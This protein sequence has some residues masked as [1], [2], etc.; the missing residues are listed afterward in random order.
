MVEMLKGIYLLSTDA[1]ELIYGGNECED[2]T[3]LVDIY[4]PPQTKE[5]V[6][7][8]PA[9]LRDADIIFSGW[10]TSRMDADFLNAATRLRAVF[11]AAGSIR[12]VVSEAFWTR[13][14]LITSAYAA[15]AIPVAEYTLS[16]ILF[17]LKL[18]WQHYI[19]VRKKKTWV[20]YKPVFG[21][22]KSTVG[23]ISLGVISRKVI[24]LL[25]PFDLK[26]LVY[27]NHL[28]EE[29]ATELNVEQCS[30]DEIFERADVV[31]LHSPSLEKTRG[32]I[33]GKH[34]ASM[35]PYASFINTA[36][37]AI[38]REDEMVKVL[39]RRPDLQAVLDVTW[40]EPPESD[41]PLY[42]LPNVALTPHIAGSMDSEC[43]RM[44]RYMVD[45]LVRFLDGEP[46][47]WAISQEKASVIA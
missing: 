18:G 20:R 7:S 29:K 16:Q 33:T 8:N 24:E 13:N 40:P 17:C 27:S 38:V 15:N 43:T 25:K 19:S 14:I 4:A 37:G 3:R 23:I 42:T 44:G 21:V 2:I 31:S 1:Y 35:K 22:Y 47:R 34:I 36:R 32:M 46:L 9:V 12:S 5:S 45:E 6:E 39:R 26:I 41:S 10:G 30:L 28:T 11:H